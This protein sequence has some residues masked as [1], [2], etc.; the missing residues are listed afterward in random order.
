MLISAVQQSD[1]VIQLYIYTY[2]YILF[3][4]LFHYDFSQDIDYK[5]F[6]VLYS[7]TLLFIYINIYIFT[8]ILELLLISCRIKKI[9][10]VI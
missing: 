8:V 1:S 3:H 9:S 6:P 2:I 7:G 4:I 5:W 10:K